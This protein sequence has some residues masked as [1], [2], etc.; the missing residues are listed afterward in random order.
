MRINLQHIPPLQWDLD[1]LDAVGRAETA[2][3]MAYRRRRLRP[4]PCSLHSLTILPSDG[5]ELLPHVI[6]AENTKL[7]FVAC[8]IE[9]RRVELK[10]LFYDGSWEFRYSWARDVDQGERYGEER[11]GDLGGGGVVLWHGRRHWRCQWRVRWTWRRGRGVGMERRTGK[12]GGNKLEW[13]R[14][15]YKK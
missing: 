9:K 5:L 15:I 2:P 12:L 11:D 6:L 13:K 4:W 1:G 7:D 8:Q 3:P 10:K 14:R